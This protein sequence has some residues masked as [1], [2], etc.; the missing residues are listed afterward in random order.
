MKKC[1]CCQA[2]LESE[3]RFCFYCMTSLE[4]KEVV[5][6]PAGRNKKW[7]VCIAALFVVALMVGGAFLLFPP[8]TKQPAPET[9]GKGEIF[10]QGTTGEST[11]EP[12][13]EDPGSNQSVSTP[14]QGSPNQSESSAPDQPV[15]S[16][17]GSVSGE[18]TP[19]YVGSGDGSS[20]PA[21]QPGQTPPSTPITQP[22]QTPPSTPVTQP[23]QTNPSTPVTQPEQTPPSTPVTQPEE[24]TPS[25]P[26]TQ[27]EQT[28][29][30]TQPEETP[31]PE[32]NDTPSTPTTSAEYEYRLAQYAVDDYH[33]TANVDDCVVITGV[34]TPASDGIY[35][36]PETLE[37]KKVITVDHFAF[38]GEEI[39]DTVREVHLPASVRTVKDNAFS[40]CRNLTDIYFEGKSIYVGSAFAPKAQRTGTLTIHSAYD[41]NNRD[42][43]YYRNIAGSYY[44]AEWS[45]L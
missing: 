13:T 37:G 16:P 35:R 42:F 31:P 32:S 19:G 25:T 2:D 4:E 10:V 26:V 36:I 27:P 43:R 7:A 45:Q 44:D 17:S 30:E 5:A 29:P 38:N 9:D 41:C 18:S 21:T 40:A 15:S 39:R 34:K 8:E 6:V 14:Q 33:V 1:P 12:N 20:A 24:T 28:T 22:E 3:A 11:G 23:E